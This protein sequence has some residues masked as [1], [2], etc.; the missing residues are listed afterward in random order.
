MTI[1]RQNLDQLLDAGKLQICTLDGK[2]YKVRRNGRTKLYKKEPLQIRLPIKW[3]FKQTGAITTTDFDN[4]S[5]EL[6]SL[7]RINPEL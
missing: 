2:W 4:V 7:F 1:T 6:I 5:G 3:G